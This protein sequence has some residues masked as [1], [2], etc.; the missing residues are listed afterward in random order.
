MKTADAP[1]VMAIVGGAGTRMYPLTLRHPK[2]LIPICNYATL[3]RS[4]ETLARQGCRDFVFASTG[5]ENTTRLKEYFKW[6]VSFSTRLGLD[7]VAL[8]RYQ[9]NYPDR[10]NADAVRTCLN[11]FNI[12]EDALIVGGDNI[13]DIDVEDMLRFHHEKG[14]IMTIGLTQVENVSQYGVADMDP[15][16]RIRRFV[17]KPKP[18]DEPT[19][20]ANIGIYLLSPKIGKVFKD[21]GEKV[22]DFGYDVIPYLIEKGY[23]VY[24]YRSSGYWNDIGTPGEYLRSTHDILAGRVKNITFRTKDKI[25]KNLWIHP[26]TLQKMEEKIEYGKVQLGKNTLIGGDCEI[27]DG[28]LIENSAIGDNCVIEEGA[29]ITGAVV[30]DFVN[31][32]A[33]VRLNNCIVGTFSTIQKDSIIDAELEVDMVSGD[34]D[35]V[36]V[37]GENVTIPPGSVIGP[38]KRV[39]PIEKSHDILKTGRYLALGYDRRNIY[40]VEE[41]P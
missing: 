24:G 12:T 40:F 36:P 26:T 13:F 21:M 23:P 39:A 4:F 5:M 11:Y 25:M 7:P 8:F 3:I 35:N 32:E 30:M 9:P 14:S 38:R 18:G 17:E 34:D 19:N 2:P 29:M 27:G 16:M 41:A 20:L 33:N 22:A 15:D 10:G 31:I 1:V 6:G 28:V 37:I